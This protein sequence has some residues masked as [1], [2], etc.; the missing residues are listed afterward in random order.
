YDWHVSALKRWCRCDT[1]DMA[2]LLLGAWVRFKNQ[3]GDSQLTSERLQ[4][5]KPLEIERPRL[6]S[7]SRGRRTPL[8]IRS[9]STLSPTFQDQP[10]GSGTTSPPS[11]FRVAMP[12]VASMLVMVATTPVVSV[13]GT[14]GATVPGPTPMTRIPVTQAIWTTCRVLIGLSFCPRAD[15][16]VGQPPRSGTR[17][18]L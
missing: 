7:C 8:A 14:L 6:Q 18:S 4:C 9:Q 16:R 12:C 2:E 15:A 5:Y 17:D 3:I 11:I 10:I 13:S 1:I